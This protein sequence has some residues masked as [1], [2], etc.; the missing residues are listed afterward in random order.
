MMLPV[1]I[2]DMRPVS[3]LEVFCLQTEEEYKANINYIHNNVYWRDSHSVHE[4]APFQGYGPFA[5]VWDALE[6]YKWIIE[7]RKIVQK[8]QNNVIHVDFKAKKRIK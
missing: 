4:V 7:E 1:H 3:S 5:T 8:H 2:I 6:H